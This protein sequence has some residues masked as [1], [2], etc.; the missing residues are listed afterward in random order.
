MLDPFIG[1]ILLSR[2]YME[3]LLPFIEKWNSDGVKK[4]TI[5]LSL[6][7]VRRILR[8]AADEWRDKQGATWL[9]IA[10]KIKMFHIMDCAQTAFSLG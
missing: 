8:L 2:V 7:I 10:P 4:K 3:T 5:N 6:E 1:D 9:A